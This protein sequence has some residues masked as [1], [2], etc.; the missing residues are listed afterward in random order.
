MNR[1]VKILIFRIKTMRNRLKEIRRH[2]TLKI[3]VIWIMLIGLFAGTFYVPYRAFIFLESMGHLGLVIIDKLLYL[4]F[5]GLFIMLIFSNCI[6][7]FSTSYKAKE[8]SFFF[9]LPLE[10]GEIFF[11][12]FLDC[13]VLS[14]WAFLCFLLPILGAYAVV[15]ELNFIFYFSMLVFFVPFAV[16]SAALGSL[17]TMLIARFF[18]SR[19]YKFIG[20]LTGLI[21]ILGCFWLLLEGKAVS[22]S[23]NEVLFLLTNF[24]P[25]FGFSQWAFAPNYWI[26]EG[27]F[28]VIAADYRA[29]L[30]WWLL[31]LSNALFLSLVVVK[32][33]KAVY[34]KGWL[35]CSGSIDKRDYK[36]QGII[37]VNVFRRLKFIPESLRSIM[38]KDIKTFWRDP[39]QWSQFTIFFG[40]LAIYFANIRNLGYE[41]VLPFWKNVICFLNLASTNLTLA[42]LSVRF[43]FPQISLEGKRFWMLGLAPVEKKDLLLE[44]FWLNSA[45][46]LSISLP[47]ILLS[48]SMLNVS[49]ELMFLSIGLVVCMGFSLIGLC[50][51]LGTVFP[52]F[53][54]DNPA[55]IVSGFGGTLAL[56][57]CLVYIVINVT[58]LA[59][60]F[61]LEITGQIGMD[62][63][64]KL[65]LF[66]GIFVAV[67]SAATVFISLY[68]ANRALEKMEF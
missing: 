18:P 8:T 55:Q 17:L 47:L 58:A 31:L 29:G 44:K 60:P 32:T 43:V 1:A 63:F 4:F 14:S 49:R 51:G 9:T 25:H 59:L 40:L 33:A 15:K 12:K 48:N 2:S 16:I 24:I 37:V 67:L 45:A 57:L 52:N 56:V 6:I 41:S 10:F 27:L 36:N 22:R 38:I 68:C 3:A 64:K 42:S 35:K 30:F 50:I 19:F 28:K 23:Q 21:F 7:C 65:I 13:I 54:E 5:M 11:V 53:K 61:H 34:F 66:A 62:F 20:A 26:S 39:L 46:A